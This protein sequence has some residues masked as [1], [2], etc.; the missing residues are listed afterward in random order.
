VLGTLSAFENYLLGLFGLL[1]IGHF[2]MIIKNLPY[3]S[4]ANSIMPKA[5]KLT[6]FFLR[7]VDFELAGLIPNRSASIF[8]PESARITA[9]STAFSSSLTFPGHP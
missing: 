5:V 7:G 9:L 1:L 3:G 4:V 2:N 8:F 6:Y